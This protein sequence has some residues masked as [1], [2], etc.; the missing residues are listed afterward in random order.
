MSQDMI[1][2]RIAQIG[3]IVP[4][5]PLDGRPNAIIPVYK[6]P[7]SKEGWFVTKVRRTFSR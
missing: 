2:A 7:K 6:D 1:R 5:G 3:Y 4:F